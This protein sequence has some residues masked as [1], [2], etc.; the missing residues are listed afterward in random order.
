[1]STP[2]YNGNQ[3]Y[4]ENPR[5]LYLTRGTE[6]L[7]GAKRQNVMSLKKKFR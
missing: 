6:K 1:M 2:V 4:R 7:N 5:K 3:R